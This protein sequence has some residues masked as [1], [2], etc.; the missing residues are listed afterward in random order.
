MSDSIVSNAIPKTSQTQAVAERERKAY[1]HKDRTD[2]R[3]TELQASSMVSASDAGESGTACFAITCAMK[4]CCSAFSAER[5]RSAGGRP[6]RG[7][8]GQ[9][10][11]VIRL[12][13][14]RK[15]RET[16]MRNKQG[17]ENVGRNV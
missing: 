8:G 9:R 14:D 17:R 7:T 4:G 3:L 13:Q 16:G 1:S 11:T 10:R 6:I 5:R 2:K 15:T 12:G